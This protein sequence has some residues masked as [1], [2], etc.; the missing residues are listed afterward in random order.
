[1]FRLKYTNPA[2]RR[3]I[4]KGGSVLQGLNLQLGFYLAKRQ[5]LLTQNLKDL[6][7]MLP[8]FAKQKAALF[9]G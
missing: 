4:A 7:Q 6:A 5:V 8:V 3:K 1:M 2:Q 9:A